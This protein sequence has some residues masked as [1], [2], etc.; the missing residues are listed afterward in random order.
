MQIKHDEYPGRTGGR[1]RFDR[2]EFAG[3]FGDVGTLVPYVVAY[4]VY[5]KMEP[6]GMLLAFGIA[7]IACGLYFLTPVPVQPMKAITVLSGGLHWPSFQAGSITWDEL[8]TGTQC[9]VTCRVI[10]CHAPLSS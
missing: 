7:L 3:A 9:C 8:V 2:L 10:A 4:A 1:L 6:T 5:A